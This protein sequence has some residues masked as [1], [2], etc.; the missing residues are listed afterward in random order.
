MHVKVIWVP[1]HLPLFF[2]TGNKCQLHYLKADCLKCN[3][4]NDKLLW[5]QQ[6]GTQGYKSTD[7]NMNGQV[8]NQ[9]KNDNWVPNNGEGSHVPE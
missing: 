3:N 1:P 2:N 9:D 5:E 4:V 6:L 7:F 8:N